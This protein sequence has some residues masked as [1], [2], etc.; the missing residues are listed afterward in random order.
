[1]SISAQYGLIGYPLSHSFSKKYFTEKFEKEQLSHCH[2][3]LYELPT[4]QNFS[5]LVANTPN[6]KGLNVTI[7]Y[8]QS[9]IPFLD[10]LDEKAQRISAVNVI[11]VL[12]NNKLRGYNSDYW[13][14]QQ[15]LKNFLAKDFPNEQYNGLNALILGS[16]GAS[17]AVQVALQDLEIPFIVVSR[18]LT[19]TTISYEQFTHYQDSCRLLINTTPLGMYPEINACPPINYDCISPHHFVLDL[20][21]NPEMTLFMQKC[22]EKGAKVQNGLEMLYLQA[23]KAWEIWQKI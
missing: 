13:G 6:L 2:Y 1:M 3:E 7:P 8:K 5:S 15:S 17:K 9:V 10:S 20:V 11:K 22:H 4:L 23:E 12:T 16:G 21:Y 14:F 19:E 18:Q